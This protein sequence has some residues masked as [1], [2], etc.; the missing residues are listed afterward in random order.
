MFHQLL[1]CAASSRPEHVL[2]KPQSSDVLAHHYLYV[3]GCHN[4]HMLAQA[5]DDGVAED[6]GSDN[7]YDLGTAEHGETK[8]TSVVGRVEDGV[9]DP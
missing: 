3:L 6:R 1:P 8:S 2:V 4:L 5:V 7:P 9:E